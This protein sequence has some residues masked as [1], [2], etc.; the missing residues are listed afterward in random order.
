MS[1]IKINAITVPADSGDALAQ[2]FAARAGSVDGQPGFEG[3]ELLKP[4]DGRNVWLVITRW[5][6]EASF[7]AWTSSANF[8]EG[9][10]GA[11]AAPE[12]AGQAPSGKPVGLSAELWSYEPSVASPGTGN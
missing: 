7:Q 4:T 3:F 9:H 5:A 6:D 2:R 11:A 1:V 10:K 12:S 8:K